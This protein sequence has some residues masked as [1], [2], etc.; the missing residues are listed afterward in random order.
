MVSILP[1]KISPWQA[2]GK[3]MS[4]LGNNTPQLLEKRYQT[5]QGLSAIDQLQESLGKS[6]GDVSQILP[7]LA[8]A[9]T[10]NPNLERSGLGQQYLQQARVGQ[11]YGQSGQK[12]PQ[13]SS[14]QSPNI[15]SNQSQP[16]QTSSIQQNAVSQS[17]EFATP[18][19]F[20][21]FT[22]QD[23]DEESKRFATAL[24]DPN[25]YNQRFSQLQAL[26]DAANGQR[27]SLE[28]AALNAG[29]DAGDLPRFMVVNSHL[30]PRNPSE[31]AQ[32]A[33][34]NFAQV[35]NNDKKLRRAF[36]P[37]I[38]SALF[39]T[40]REEALKNLTPTLQD[41]KERG[42]EQEDRQYLAGEHLS[43]TEIELAYHPQTPKLKKGIS[44][45]P[46]GLFPAQTKSTWSDVEKV[47]TEGKLP[48]SK[49]SPFVSYDE[50]LEKDPEIIQVMQNRLA[51]FFKN[52]VDNNTSL[53][54][55]RHS[56]WKDKDYDWR[57]I[58]PAIRQATAQGLRLN[59]DQERELAD[60]ETQAPM[61]SL[62]DLFKDVL[63]RT[64]AIIRGNK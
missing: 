47:F 6:N 5:Q 45:F 31:W 14:E 52:N 60:L 58:G 51:D 36:I 7:A 27:Q 57:Q 24:N 44:S 43:P 16:Q 13:I 25:A 53:L 49:T 40:N 32:N 59:A 63:N 11:A 9:Y 17:Q 62:P 54:G 39:G 4:E 12:Q 41:N 19:P 34:R 61:E 2:I 42:L 15:A 33:K 56:L 18:S 20:N 26:N 46:K 64:P 21:V 30:D 35:N 23:S 1:P 55:I 29:V 48:N 37:G 38:G 8:K 10:L 50:A 3:A 22:P 28:Q